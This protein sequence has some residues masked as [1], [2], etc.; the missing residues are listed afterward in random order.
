MAPTKAIQKSSSFSLDDIRAAAERRYGAVPFDLPDGRTLKLLNALRLPKAK[1]DALAE[2]QKRS[3]DEDVDQE[4][5]L[6]AMLKL[7]A[8]DENLVDEMVASFD[9]DL[10]CVA[11]MF[12]L[13][14]QETE[15]GEA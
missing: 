4:A 7:L 3:K 5:E 12:D 1:R 14:K 15:P 8:D 9:G 13:Y 2:T 6:V 11:A 10:G